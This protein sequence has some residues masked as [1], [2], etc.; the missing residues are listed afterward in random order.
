MYD[1]I[2]VVGPGRCGSSTVAGM[3]RDM[4][5]DMGQRFRPADEQNPNGYW[6]DLD[7]R[8]LNQRFLDGHISR[9]D[10]TTQLCQLGMDRRRR[11]HPW[12][13]KDPRIADLIEPYLALFPRALFVRCKRP[14]EDVI[15]SHRRCYAWE[16][17][18]AR[19]RLLQREA[20]LDTFVD[21]ALRKIDV[22]I[23]TLDTTAKE[24]LGKILNEQFFPSQSAS[25]PNVMVSIPHTSNIQAGTTG[26]AVR[27]MCTS[28][29]VSRG[30]RLSYKKPYVHNLHTLA[31]TMLDDGFDYWF[32][33]DSD[34]AP[35]ENCDPLDLVWA[36]LD[37]VGCLYPLWQNRQHC[38]KPPFLMSAFRRTGEHFFPIM[39]V[40]HGLVEVDAIASGCML[41]ARRVIEKMKAPFLREWDP[42]S[43]LV[44]RGTDMA[45]C[46]RAKQAGFRVWSHM[47]Y[48][49]HHFNTID[50]VEAI[51]ALWMYAQN[52]GALQGNAPPISLPREPQHAQALQ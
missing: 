11:L 30:L 24:G 31:K 26:A 3:L 51:E 37:V 38:V 33:M 50:L 28:E 13:F 41:I 47:D 6:E 40:C 22:P 16:E 29:R 18:Y 35:F 19:H 21:S 52:M 7:F 10:F 48:K 4:G 5:V 14:I 34:N 36:D 32:N 45:F 20:K 12:G 44:T 15:S 25:Q 2:I 23:E 9:L 42:D 49:A 1:P 43:G 17:E 39:D 46:T 27:L 8:D